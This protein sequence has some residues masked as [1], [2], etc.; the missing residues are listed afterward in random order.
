MGNIVLWDTVDVPFKVTL[1]M[2]FLL[3]SALIVAD[4]GD[5]GVE[6]NGNA[7]TKKSVVQ[8]NEPEI[9]K[10]SSPRIYKLRPKESLGADTEVSFPADI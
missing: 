1:A 5:K 3:C 7:S 8:V 9:K 4:S 2:V 6:S 10:S